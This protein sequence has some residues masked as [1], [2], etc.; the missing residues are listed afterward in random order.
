[1]LGCIIKIDW[2][3]AIPI[4]TPEE[5]GVQAHLC[6]IHPMDSDVRGN[7]QLVTVAPQIAD[8]IVAKFGAGCKID[9]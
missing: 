6:L 2:L 5:T 7:D 3:S 1:M 9:S 4:V 8:M